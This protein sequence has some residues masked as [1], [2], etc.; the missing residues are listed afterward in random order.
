MGRNGLI[1]KEAKEKV[2]LA[3]FAFCNHLVIHLFIYLFTC[4]FLYLFICELPVVLFLSFSFLFTH[5][6]TYSTEVNLKAKF[7]F[8]A[9]FYKLICS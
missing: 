4:L 9:H 5:N 8:F 3:R 6:K 7:Y 1:C 2:D